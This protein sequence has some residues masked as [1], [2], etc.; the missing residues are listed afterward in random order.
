MQA[1][2][3]DPFGQHL[4][5]DEREDPLPHRARGLPGVPLQEELAEGE[6]QHELAQEPQPGVAVPHVARARALGGGVQV[7]EGEVEEDVEVARGAVVALA[8]RLGG[9]ERVAERLLG[10][11]EVLVHPGAVGG[12]ERRGGEA[13]GEQRQRLERQLRAVEEPLGEALVVERR[14]EDEPPRRVLLLGR[15]GLLPL[16]ELPEEPARAVR[17][18]RG[19]GLRGRRGLVGRHGEH[20]GP[21][22]RG[23]EVEGRE[24]ERLERHGGRCHG[25]GRWVLRF[26]GWRKGEE[27]GRG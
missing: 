27:G 11:E 22:P 24:G 26:G 13:G 2:R 4:L 5:P 16:R 17:R 8:E 25:G 14:L 18:L 10:L 21:A 9:G 3:L 1:G 6:L 23:G 12:G 7:L 15:D 20:A 19:G